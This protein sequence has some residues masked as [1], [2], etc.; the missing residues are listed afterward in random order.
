M[1]YVMY[2]S[3]L[4]WATLCSCHSIEK[5]TMNLKD[6]KKPNTGLTATA[7]KKTNPQYRNVYLHFLF[8]HPKHV[9]TCKVDYVPHNPSH[10]TKWNLVQLTNLRNKLQFISSQAVSRALTVTSVCWETARD[11]RHLEMHNI[12]EYE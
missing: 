6:Y 2:K 5:P 1:F 11:S 4:S 9:I 3:R 8:S 10:T 12:P 7:M